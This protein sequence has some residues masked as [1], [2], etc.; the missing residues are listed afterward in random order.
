MSYVPPETEL[1]IDAVPFSVTDAGALTVN[2]GAAAAGNVSEISLT[3]KLSVSVSVSV[4]PSRATPSSPP[5]PCAVTVQLIIALVSALIVAGVY[6]TLS[7]EAEDKLPPPELI[8]QAYVNL[9]YV[10]PETLVVKVWDSSSSSD[11]SELTVRVGA[12][13]S[14]KIFSTGFTTTVPNAVTL[15]LVPITASDPVPVTLATHEL[16]TE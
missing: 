4:V 1:V 15:S 16:V 8:L 13:A 2:V 3:V 10:P 12:S 14:A 9:S 6:V 11:S 5:S 7:P